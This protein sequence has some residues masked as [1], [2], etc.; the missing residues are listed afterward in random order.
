[1]K[2]CPLIRRQGLGHRRILFGTG[3]ILAIAQYASAIGHQ[4]GFDQGQVTEQDTQLSDGG[5]IP[6]MGHI[7]L[8]RRIGGVVLLIGSDDAGIFLAVQLHQQGVR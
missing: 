4:R 5:Q 6:S 7:H 1:M 8:A 3:P 2:S